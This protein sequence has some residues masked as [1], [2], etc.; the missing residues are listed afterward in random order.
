MI[1]LEAIVAGLDLGLKM[2]GGSGVLPLKAGFFDIYRVKALKYKM[3]VY[4][5]SNVF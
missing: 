1:D 3:L 5:L 2:S 4:I